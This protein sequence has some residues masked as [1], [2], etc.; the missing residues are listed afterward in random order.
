ML[1]DVKVS[2]SDLFRDEALLDTC[3]KD[4]EGRR[5]L[6]VLGKT[7]FWSGDDEFFTETGVALEKEASCQCLISQG[8]SFFP[9]LVCRDPV[10][11]YDCTV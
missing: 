6:R 1:H 5:C 3:L 10:A 4:P 11:A 2:G 9:V 7:M 8:A